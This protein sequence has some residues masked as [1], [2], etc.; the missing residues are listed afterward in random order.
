MKT[1]TVSLEVEIDADS[2]EEAAKEFFQAVQPQY[3]LT[4]E[5]RDSDGT[6]S[7]VLSRRT[8]NSRK[9]EM[10]SA[11]ESAGVPLGYD[12]HQLRSTQVEELVRIAKAFGYHASKGAPGSTA[13][14]LYEYLNRGGVGEHARA[15]R[16]HYR[17]D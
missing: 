1:Y 12:F 7:K 4:A 3:R 9:A 8:M 14:M 16:D 17:K 13:R 6:S 10:L 11:A 2:P 5:V 15:V